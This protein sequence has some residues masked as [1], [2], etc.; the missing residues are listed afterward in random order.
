M[1]YTDHV[2][3]YLNCRPLP[4]NTHV[5]FRPLALW[6]EKHHRASD[7]PYA[8]TS[9]PHQT[10]N[11]G[12]AIEFDNSGELAALARSADTDLARYGIEPD[13]MP[14]VASHKSENGMQRLV[15][16]G[17]ELK[18]EKQSRADQQGQQPTTM[19]GGLDS[20][21]GHDSADELD[22]I[23]NSSPPRITR[24]A[25]EKQAHVHQEVEQ[26][27]YKPVVLQKPTSRT[28]PP[29]LPGSSSN[30]RP[31]S[32][33]SIRLTHAAAGT[34]VEIRS[35]TTS[36][37]TSFAPPRRAILPVRGTLHSQ[38][39]PLADNLSG[40]SLPQQHQSSQSA[41]RAS[42]PNTN[43]RHAKSRKLAEDDDHSSTAAS[44]SGR[45]RVA[46]GS[47]EAAGM[48]KDD[49]IEIEDDEME[50]R[51]RHEEPAD[52][53][54]RRP[55]HQHQR[56]EMVYTAADAR[57]GVHH[58]LGL[59]PGGPHYRPQNGP[60]ANGKPIEIASERRDP[61]TQHR[62]GGGGLDF[63]TKRTIHTTPPPSSQAG[64]SVHR[65]QFI[66]LDDDDEPAPA[67][68]ED[69]DDR[70]SSRRTLSPEAP[71]LDPG[72][73]KKMLADQLEQQRRD[74]VPLV[75]FSGGKGQVVSKV[76]ASGVARRMKGKTVR[77][78]S[79]ALML[80]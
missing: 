73:V 47:R 67:R 2:L 33:T 78:S 28:A 52:R 62:G 74:A 20:L 48:R 38:R 35:Q 40:S 46:S 68:G 34:T 9:D 10:A 26:S 18:K 16:T 69:P 39:D 36:S 58:D 79:V 6:T 25:M 51:P 21:R 41:S 8:R 63:S 4:A 1:S 19:P 11:T 5:P 13:Q 53:G 70:I 3:C 24:R 72:M 12:F 37:T 50:E 77:S 80:L 61:S 71:S 14:I 55:A 45:G 17:S 42:A 31:T 15:P 30:Q 54:R 29:P 7:S 75:D 44:A 59:T 66:D 60:S 23:N 65:E 56:D 43:G 27:G 57:N 76:V 49:A 32:Q 22:L 64:R